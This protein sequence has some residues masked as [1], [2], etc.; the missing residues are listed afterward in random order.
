MDM[1]AGIEG[2]SPCARRSAGDTALPL[3]EE[4]DNSEPDVEDEEVYQGGWP[5]KR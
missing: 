2:A 4:P 3:E 5:E 1:P